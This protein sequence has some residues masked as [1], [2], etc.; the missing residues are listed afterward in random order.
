M[1]TQK[2]ANEAQPGYHAAA[3]G[4]HRGWLLAALV[5]AAAAVAFWVLASTGEPEIG[6]GDT[7]TRQD[8]TNAAIAADAV[9]DRTEEG[10][11]KRTE[12]AAIASKE[13]ATV[14]PLD[15]SNPPRE[16]VVIRVVDGRTLAPVSGATV[17]AD[18]D[19]TSRSQKR[20][21]LE[22]SLQSAFEVNLRAGQVATTD[23]EG[24]V[25]FKLHDRADV[26]AAKGDL[27]VATEVDFDHSGP[28][29]V[30]LELQPVRL[31]TIAVVEPDGAPCVGVP[32]GLQAIF[33]RGEMS[34][35]SSATAIGRS[36]EDGTLVV[37]LDE[38]LRK[39]APPRSM[40][41]YCT[42]PGLTVARVP[43]ASDQRT[44]TMTLPAHARVIVRA[45]D[46]RGQPLADQ[47]TWY[48]Q[49]HERND[50][51]ETGNEEHRIDGYAFGA[52]QGGEVVFPYVGLGL[53]LN[54][55]CNTSNISFNETGPG[56]TQSGQ[57]VVYTFSLAAQRHF[58]L[59]AR[60]LDPDGTPLADARVIVANRS[61]SSWHENTDA[62]GRFGLYI[63]HE[64]DT[65]TTMAMQLAVSHDDELPHWFEPFS[66]SVNQPCD[67]GDIRVEPAVVIA[68]GKVVHDGSMPPG[69][70]MEVQEYHDDD[71]QRVSNYKVQR[72]AD[73]AFVVVRLFP[74]VNHRLRL[75]AGAPG[76]LQVPPIDFVPGRDDLLVELRRGT[77]VSARLQ[78]DSSVVW[79]VEDSGLDLLFR[80]EDGNQQYVRGLMQKGEWVFDTNALVPGIY[81][82]AVESGS[83]TDDLAHIEAVRIMPGEPTD[84]RLQPWDLRSTIQLMTIRARS[85]EGR[86]L[87]VRGEVN[88]RRRIDGEWEGS[89]SFDN[90]VA[91]FLTTAEPVDL[92][93]QIEGYGPFLLTNV[94]GTVDLVL[95]Q[96]VT[97]RIQVDD[98]PPIKDEARFHADLV[99]VEGWARSR[100]LMEDSSAVIDCE[101]D[102]TTRICSA[103][104]VAGAAATMRFVRYVQVNGEDQ[105]E[106]LGQV[107]LL[108][109]DG[110]SEVHVSVP[111]SVRATLLPWFGPSVPPPVDIGR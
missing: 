74:Q 43:V 82:I 16:H 13:P 17:A 93:V 90:G 19:G 58:S 67:L 6:L 81:S 95:P 51:A 23:A 86:S 102:A 104:V 37:R 2:S 89:G 78:L 72:T 97:V 11:Q 79:F 107:P 85:A 111:A 88:R 103:T 105:E 45:V 76:Y 71:W 4:A 7:P 22:Q 54:R 27:F 87:D 20:L 63:G 32:L 96:P 101:W 15:P 65:P 108:F 62:E 40:R 110:K 5:L 50:G 14:R 28:E 66:L 99:T 38:F 70:H 109:S 3:G 56:P 47:P 39:G 1:S 31:L 100:G 91:Q 64:D 77:F 21:L 24:Y 57:E 84:P 29:G 98:L 48:A 73:D 61:G 106:V 60:L 55:F 94:Q 10:T 34:Q 35:Q 25:S 49:L 92:C 53:D 8:V 30:V 41:V 68:R 36:G 26:G 83:A 12:E 44:V 59:K 80:R 69:L 9:F 33:A 46:E 75:V 52:G 18:P 42:A